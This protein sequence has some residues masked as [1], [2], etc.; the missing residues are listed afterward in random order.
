VTPLDCTSVVESDGWEAW[1]GQRD[2]GAVESEQ[3]VVLRTPVV[4][5]SV[6]GGEH[7]GRVYWREV[8]RITGRLVQARERQGAIELRVLGRGPSLLRFGP[9]TI[10][11]TTTLVC[12]RYPIEGGLLAR[13]PAG[14]IIFAQVGDGPPV[15]RSAIRGFFPS[16]ASRTASRNWT[17]AL[18]NQVQS[19]IHVVVSR[20]YFARLIAETRE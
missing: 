13:R 15:V 19:R 6:T 9:P 14:E 11:A 8:E 1:Q 10:K 7:L 18:Y 17:G 12:C 16:L 5:F 4:E 2:D 3:R 20:R